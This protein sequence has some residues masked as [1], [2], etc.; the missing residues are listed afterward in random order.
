MAYLTMTDLAE[1]LDTTPQNVT[2]MVAKYRP[3]NL[4]VPRSRRLPPS[5]VRDI[6]QSR[7]FVAPRGQTIGM[8][9]LKGGVGK[10]SIGLHF[11]LRLQALGMSVLFI[12]YGTTE[13]IF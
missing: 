12:D 1:F 8:L 7:A 3:A 11:S 4:D 6:L 10:S 9:N 13:M 5:V 2:K